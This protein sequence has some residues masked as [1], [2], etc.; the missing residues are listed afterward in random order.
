R[1]RMNNRTMTALHKAVLPRSFDLQAR[2]KIRNLDI[3]AIKY[4]LVK[5]AGWDVARA[6]RVGV[7]YKGFLLLHILRPR[8]MHI[9]TLEIDEMWHAH[10][11]DTAK[12]MRDCHELFGSYLHHFPY[13]GLRG[14]EDAAFADQSF[15]KT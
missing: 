11:L 4:K 14:E 2:A 10:I 1:L 12:Y 9:P 5:E 6:D 3:E 13:V 8:E 15:V 7:L